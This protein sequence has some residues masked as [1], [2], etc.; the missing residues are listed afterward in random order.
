VVFGRKRDAKGAQKGRKRGAKGAQKG[1][2]RGAK[3]AQK[4]PKKGANME[5]GRKRVKWGMRKTAEAPFIL[6]KSQ[7]LSA[8]A[9]YKKNSK[10]NYLDCALFLTYTNMCDMC[11]F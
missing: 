2:K 4:G 1:R 7:I 10:K 11:Y 3:E 6:R 9:F 5:M 8:F